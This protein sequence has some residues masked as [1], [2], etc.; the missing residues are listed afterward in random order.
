[1]KKK[2]F[3]FNSLEK[4]F[5]GAQSRVKTGQKPAPRATG[6]QPRQPRDFCPRPQPPPKR[7]PAP[8]PRFNPAGSAFT[9]GDVFENLT[10]QSRFKTDSFKSPIKPATAGA[11]R[12]SRTRF[13]R[14]FKSATKQKH[15]SGNHSPANHRSNSD[16]NRGR[17]AHQ[18]GQTCV[19]PL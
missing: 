16:V 3:F 12:P 19:A 15:A 1:M 8:S 17:A 14:N 4:A 9:R 7:G 2:N 6:G 11:E 13:H 18:R 10:V 5:F